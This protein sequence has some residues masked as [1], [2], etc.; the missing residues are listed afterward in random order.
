ML[1]QE[2]KRFRDRAAFSVLVFFIGL[3]IAD[4]VFAPAPVPD[5]PDFVDTLLAS[6]AVV[7]VIRIAIVFAG[8][9]LVLSVVALAIR[10]Q[11][12]TRLGPVEVEKVRDLDAENG[13]FEE[14]L[15]DA[16]QKIEALEERAAYT[17]QVIH[18]EGQ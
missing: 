10:G 7:A 9:F 13:R 8:L 14:R 6:R 11:W 17:Q 4:A 18:Q 3:A 12:L 5:Q 16:N 15:E 1:K 2:E